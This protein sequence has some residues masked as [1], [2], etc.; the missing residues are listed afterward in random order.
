MPVARPTISELLKHYPA[1]KNINRDDLFRS[2]GWD[3]EIN[4]PAFL[5]TC[6]IVDGFRKPRI[7]GARVL[8][9]LNFVH[10]GF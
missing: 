10:P 7:S 2:I 8:T 3:R 9:F 5:D 4:N 1:T 6:A